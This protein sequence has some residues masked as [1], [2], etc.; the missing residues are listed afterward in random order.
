[1]ADGE[2]SYADIAAEG[3]MGDGAVAIE[4]SQTEETPSESSVA[5][6]DSSADVM[7]NESLQALQSELVTATLS[8][9][10][11]ST[12]MKLADKD[13][14]GYN[15]EEG[16]LLKYQLDKLEQSTKRLCL[17][18]PFREKCLILSHD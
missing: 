6:E 18:E 11:L 5:Q 4:A 8:Y 13:A 15:W 16:L 3:D 12:L 1:M 2:D 17:P 14:S 10:T 7:Q 9:P